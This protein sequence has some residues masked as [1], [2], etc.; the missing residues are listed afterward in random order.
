MYQHVP[1]QWEKSLHMLRAISL[2]DYD[3]D[4][5]VYCPMWTTWAPVVVMTAIGLTLCRKTEYTNIWKQHLKRVDCNIP[6][7][8]WDDN[9]CDK[10]LISW[11]FNLKL[12]LLRE[13][14]I[15]GVYMIQR[16]WQTTCGCSTHKNLNKNKNLSLMSSIWRIQSPPCFLTS[17]YTKYPD[18]YCL[19]HFVY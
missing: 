7:M 8:Q 9:K 19:T 14:K 5:W 6:A 11:P 13:K 18:Y 17:W 1:I 2:A 4:N 12:Y 10:L 3:V 16:H 15:Q